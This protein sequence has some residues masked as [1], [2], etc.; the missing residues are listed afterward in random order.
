ML[1]YSNSNYSNHSNYSNYSN[2]QNFNNNLSF[3]KKLLSR[4]TKSNSVIRNNL[5]EQAIEQNK[6]NNSTI[7]NSIINNSTTNNSIINNSITNNSITNNNESL[8]NTKERWGASIWFLFHTLAEKIIENDFE[9]IKNQ[10]IDI[11]KGICMNL[12]CPTCSNHATQYIQKLN[13]VSI[14]NKDDLKI[15]L[16]NFHNDVNRRKNVKLFSLEEL[17]SKYSKSNTLNVINNFI[18]VYQYKNKSFNMIANEMQKQRQLEL[19]KI[20]IKQNIQSFLL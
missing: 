19:F 12:P 2:N 17:N 16:L 7:N 20:W 3:G 1:F 14:R 13:Y 10:L 5:K 6:I 11:I 15:F 8:E 4:I 18:S 9:K